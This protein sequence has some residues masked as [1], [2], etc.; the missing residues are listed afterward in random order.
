M[1]TRDLDLN[2]LWLASGPLLTVGWE[3]L[4]QDLKSDI[5]FGADVLADHGQDPRVC[6]FNIQRGLSFENQSETALYRNYGSILTYLS[7]GLIAVYV[8]EEA[9]PLK[10]CSQP[11]LFKLF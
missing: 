4:L 2:D 9:D 7:L 11:W 6:D 10:K 8:W 5:L 3:T 1:I